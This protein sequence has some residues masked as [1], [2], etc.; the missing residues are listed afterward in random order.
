M[1]SFNLLGGCEYRIYSIAIRKVLVV[2]L[3]FNYNSV[4]TSFT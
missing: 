3:C 4:K 2:F 1:A